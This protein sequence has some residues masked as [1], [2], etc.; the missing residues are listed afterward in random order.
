[1][2]RVARRK[3]WVI[4][5]ASAS[6]GLTA[7]AQQ[8]PVFVFAGQSNMVGYQTDSNHLT[9]AQRAAQPNVLW[10]GPQYSGTF[11]WGQMSAPTETT[12]VVLSQRGFGMEL[13]APLTISNAN[14]GQKVG[15][16]KYAVNATD[17]FQQWNPST[18]G[19]LYS[20]MLS[21]VNNGLTQ[22]P[23]KQPGTTGAVAGFF[24]MQGEGD[25]YVEGSLDDERPDLY[26]HNLTQLIARVRQDFGD[27]NLPFIFGQ[28]NAAGT[29]TATVRRAH[30][31]VAKLVPRTAYVLTDDLGH[32]A[33]DPI[34]LSSLGTYDTGVRMG[35][36]WQA[37]V[38]GPAPTNTSR[39]LLRNGDF[40]DY[41]ITRHE[42]V[43]GNHNGA[44]FPTGLIPG[45]QDLNAGASMV[46]AGAFGA[47]TASASLGQQF[48][49]LQ[50]GIFGSG[51]GGA[52][53]SVATLAGEDYQL[54]FNYSALSR[55]NN[56]T[57]SFTYD[58]GGAATTLSVSTSGVPQ[59]RTATWLAQT[60]DFV[61]N[62]SLTTVRFL[63]TTT[64]DDGTIFGPAIDNVQLF[65]RKWDA[66]AGDWNTAANWSGSI[67][68]AVGAPANF[69]GVITAPRTITN[70]A[71]VTVGSIRFNNS[72]SYTIAGTGSLTL[73]VNS[74][75]ASIRSLAGA[76]QINLPLRLNRS[77]HVEVTSG[78]QLTLGG[79]TTLATG[80]TL[81]K[82]GAGTLNIGSGLTQAGAATVELNAGV[83]NL[84]GNVNVSALHVGTGAM[85]RLTGGNRL[86]THALS[87]S[88]M[89]DLGTS[90]AIIDYT[91]TTVA[92]SIRAMI[93]GGSLTSSAADPAKTIGYAD[94]TVTALASFA[95]QSVDATSV[96][97]R[98]TFVGDTDLN[99]AVDVDDLGRLASHWQSAGP[100]TSG[101]F[102]FNNTVDVNDLGLLAVNWQAGVSAAPLP[103]SE[104]LS[105]LGLAV[106]VPEQNSLVLILATAALKCRRRRSRGLA[107][108]QAACP[109]AA[110]HPR[111]MK[112][113]ANR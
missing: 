52:R 7:R 99:G 64:A 1:M 41:A 9:P 42:G 2:A 77:T 55:G 103:L 78:A 66:Q 51:N 26:Q 20:Q 92:D 80:T 24:W 16:V 93:V 31:N 14:A 67:P 38:N 81:T 105:N 33:G 49:A 113:L 112:R 88:G 101:D 83:T 89:L 60:V 32:V 54:V 65:Q 3:A 36:A 108:V 104:A 37:I 53:Q 19:G 58:L 98:L 63:P 40:E 43:P 111:R 69:L 68:N 23:I 71:S 17:L 56:A 46:R 76:H 34:H 50:N 87:L 95:G 72:N 70:N 86:V 15:V 109:A 6:A 21:R 74:G 96:L 4:V 91:G 59:N 84:G 13:T 8:I 73:D 106:S 45:W 100:W 82:L 102:D 75:S 97:A 29:Y 10:A 57:V 28:I 35:Q 5:A 22:L 47:N 94:N 79:S 18:P 30:E 110:P 11:T 61:A 27:P 48:L 25:T 39:N 85:G 107:P 44:T 90:S 12:P 62:G